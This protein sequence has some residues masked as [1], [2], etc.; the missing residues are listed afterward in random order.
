[1]A[2]NV[3]PTCNGGMLGGRRV[4]R[5]VAWP[6]LTP[7]FSSSVVYLLALLCYAFVIKK[8]GVVWLALELEMYH[9]S[10]MTR[11][12]SG[13]CVEGRVALPRVTPFL[14]F[15]W[16]LCFL[17]PVVHVLTK[18]GCGVV[19]TTVGRM[20][21]QVMCWKTDRTALVDANFP[22]TMYLLVVWF[23]LCT[24]W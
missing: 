23:F 10:T 22:F 6:R 19:G 12:W 8:R 13:W 5:R 2:G 24:H 1:M 15:L 14:I 18:K 3:L 17:R 20:L 16:F 11:Y 21:G 4:E 9:Q 7:K